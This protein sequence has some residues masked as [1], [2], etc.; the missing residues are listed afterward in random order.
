MTGAR[1]RLLE[2]PPPRRQAASAMQKAHLELGYVARAH[3]L[4][5]EVSIKTY[6]AASETL[7]DVPRALFRLRDGSEREIQIEEVREGSKGELLLV[8]A[9]IRKRPQSEKLV[10]S[11]VFVFREDVAAPAEGEF[12]MG[13]LVGLTVKNEAGLEVGKVESL[14]DSGPV[15]N[16]V[17]KTTAGEEL[18]V[19]FVEDFVV[20]VDLPGQTLTIRPPEYT[21]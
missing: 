5:G 11:A 9:G 16:L 18:M 4:D 3:G 14:L 8:L 6:D 17:I 7:Y 10:G 21:E 1:P 20:S 15:P 2:P 12:F 13:D 19:P